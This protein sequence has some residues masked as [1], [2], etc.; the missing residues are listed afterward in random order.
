M[1][2]IANPLIRG[3]E[4]H[5][6]LQFCLC[7]YGYPYVNSESPKTLVIVPEARSKRSRYVQRTTWTLCDDRQ[8]YFRKMCCKVRQEFAKLSLRNGLIGSIPISSAKCY[9]GMV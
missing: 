8:I 4:S 3:F 6:V 7:V 5:P 2:R 9:S 1:A